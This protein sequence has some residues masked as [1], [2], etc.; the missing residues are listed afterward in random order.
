MVIPREAIFGIYIHKTIR[1]DIG[2]GNL[3]LTVIR[4][5]WGSFKF[6]GGQMLTS[7]RDA[8]LHVCLHER[9][10]QHKQYEFAL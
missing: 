1:T 4:R 10:K 3:T 2:Y 6:T 8:F 9:H 5:P 7:P